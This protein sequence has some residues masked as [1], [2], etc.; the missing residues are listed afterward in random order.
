[1]SR[2][3]FVHLDDGSVL[4]NAFTNTYSLSSLPLSLC[5]ADMATTKSRPPRGGNDATCSLP[6]IP[7][8]VANTSTDSVKNSR[9]LKQRSSGGYKRDKRK[10]SSSSSPSL[11]SINLASVEIQCT[12]VEPLYCGHL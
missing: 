8:S 4:H 2:G 6:S 10:P 1:M 12:R 9:G 3:S 7:S 5:N 11:V